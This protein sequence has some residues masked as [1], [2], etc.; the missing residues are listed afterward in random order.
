MRK[1]LLALLCAVALPVFAVD[2]PTNTC[3]STS[4]VAKITGKWDSFRWD[5]TVYETQLCTIYLYNGSTALNITGYYPT[6]MVAKK[7]TGG[8][9]ENLTLA[10]ADI[11]NNG[12]NVVI[13][14]AYTNVPADGRYLAE[15]WAYVGT[16]TNAGRVL[17]QGTIDTHGSI[18]S[19][20]ANE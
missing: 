11:T 12:T 9:T 6:F 13:T 16:A 19:T 18:H 7:T 4:D 2:F 8:Q 10:A 17:A 5:W 15:L 14:V 20:K 3:I 1:L